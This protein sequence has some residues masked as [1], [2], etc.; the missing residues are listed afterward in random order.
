MSIIN[1]IC[2][3]VQK[4]RAREVQNLVN[5][6]LEDG[7][8]AKEILNDALCPGMNAVGEKFKNN[9]IYVPE[10]LIA[11]RAMSKATEI[12]KPHLVREGVEPVGKAVICTVKG[13][14]HDIG[15]NL[16]KIM[17]EGAGIECIDLGTDAD[18]E[19]VVKAVKESGAQIVS[20][21]ALLT[22]TMPNQAE[23]IKALE[24]AGLRDKVTVMIGGAPVSQSY[25]EEI[26]A[27][28]YTSDAASCADAALAVLKK[29]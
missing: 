9:E 14:L 12:L 26:G 15:K 28:I 13:D 10:V 3:M 7:I 6:A 21:S 19:S 11:A 24:A 23:I 25:A 18:G 1:D 22:T 5:Q 16:V 27:D 20:L 29:Q 8:S 4:G 17:F 2:E